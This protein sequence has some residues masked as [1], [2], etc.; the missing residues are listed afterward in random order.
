MC[1]ASRPPTPAP[2]CTV[3][4]RSSGRLVMR[5]NQKV[6]PA[7]AADLDS[8]DAVLAGERKDRELSLIV[9]EVRASAPPMSA[10]FAARLDPGADQGVAGAETA[11]RS[12]RSWRPPLGPALG[13]GIAG[14]FA[15]VIGVSVSNHS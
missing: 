2:D 7:V 10:A 5:R 4:P 14:V 8:L 11:P 1:S 6:D 12:R 9:D 15:L 3:L 13:L